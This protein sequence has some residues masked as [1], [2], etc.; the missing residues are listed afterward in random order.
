MT[1][2]ALRESDRFTSSSL[3]SGRRQVARVVLAALLGALIGQA[4]VISKDAGSLA[5]AT[6]TER[7]YLDMQGIASGLRKSSDAGQ[8]TQQ[9][10]GHMPWVYGPGDLPLEM[11]FE[12]VGL[13]SPLDRIAGL[14]EGRYIQ[15]LIPDPWGNAYLANVDGL[16]AGT[17]RIKV[18][19]AGPDGVI[20]TAPSAAG[21]HGDDILIQLF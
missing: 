1:M 7:A 12:E 17:Q 14:G 3:P 11:P 19:S 8:L 4:G 21:A 6:R 9:E 16:E 10:S 15:I 18:L 2:P 13:A 20:D 5:A